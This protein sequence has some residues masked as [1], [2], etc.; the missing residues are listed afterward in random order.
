MKA[1]VLTKFGPPDVLQIQ[2]VAKPAPRDNEVLIRIYATTVPAGECELR[3]LRIPFTLRLP[4]RIYV[5]RIRPKPIILGQELAGEIE[6]AGKE[7]TRF[8]K[9]DQVFG[10]TGLGLG[11]YAE[12]KC[13]PEK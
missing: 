1:I 8:K 11:A 9:G 10:W 7:V 3:P 2:E 4:L 12:Y 6:E 13:L 5:G